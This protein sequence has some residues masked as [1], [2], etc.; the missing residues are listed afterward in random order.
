MAS[1]DFVFDAADWTADSLI[2]RIVAARTQ[3]SRRAEPLRMFRSAVEGASPPPLQ[4][5][6]RSRLYAPAREA[7]RVADPRSMPLSVSARRPFALRRIALESMCTAFEVRRSGFQSARTV[8]E[9]GCLPPFRRVNRVCRGGRS[10]CQ[11]PRPHLFYCPPDSRCNR[12]ISRTRCSCSQ[13]RSYSRSQ[14]RR[15]GF[16]SKSHSGNVS[17]CS[18]VN[19]PRS[20]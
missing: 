6:P 9:T 10:R 17:N 3:R 11:W 7:G 1:M 15:G 12:S 4:S 8:C 13:S 18:A 16:F 14:R 20:G 2:G 5:H 19:S